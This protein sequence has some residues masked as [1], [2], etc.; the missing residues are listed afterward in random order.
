MRPISFSYVNTRKLSLQNKSDIQKMSYRTVS[1]NL[2]FG[3]LLLFVES[4]REDMDSHYLTSLELY[5]RFLTEQNV[6]DTNKRRIENVLLANLVKVSDLD[7]V[8]ETVSRCDQ[9]TDKHLFF[10]SLDSLECCDR[11]L[12]N[13][14]RL[15]KRFDLN[16][17][18][19]E[20]IG[21]G[22]RHTV[23]ELCSLL[24]TYNMP[25]KAKFNVALEN[26][27][28]A[29]FKAGYG[30]CP[31]ESTE[32]IVEYFLT[33]ESVI[34]DKEYD[35][36]INV[37]ETNRFINK[38]NPELEYVF[39]A[40]KVKGNSFKDKAAELV[41]QCETKECAAHMSQLAKIKNEKQASAYID[42][43]IEMIIADEI[44]K[45]DSL[46]LLK[47]IYIIPLMGNVSKE[48]VNYKVEMSRSKIKMKKKITGVKNDAFI[49]DLLDDG[50]MIDYASFVSE[51]TS[52]P[53][54]ILD[55]NYIEETDPVK[56]LEG[57]GSTD[58]IKDIIKSFKA[59]NE[60]ST[61]KFRNMIS[62]IMTKSPENIIDETP[63]IFSVVRIM[64]YLGV[65]ASSPLGPVFAAILTLVGKLLTMHLDIKQAEK[66]VRH[67]RSEKEK[68]EKKLEKLSG[69]EKENQEEYIDCI[70]KC[71]KKVEKFIA[72]IDDENEEIK[73]KGDDDF[74]FDF[75][76]DDLEESAVAYETNP[77][78]LLLNTTGAKEII[79]SLE[80][81]MDDEILSNI[82]VLF[83]NCPL[84]IKNE[85]YAKLDSLGIDT[86]V[87]ESGR[88]TEFED[89]FIVQFEAVQILNELSKD[90]KKDN[91]KVKVLPK[92]NKV[93][94]LKN[95]EIQKD[96]KNNKEIPNKV[97]N[98][99]QDIKGKIN[100]GI[101]NGKNNIKGNNKGKQQ[102][103]GKIN[104]T[105]LKMAV[106]NFKKKF[107]DLKGKE[108]ELWRNIDIATVNLSKGVQQA[109]TSDRREAIIKGSI[110][111]SFSKCIK[112]AIG[113]GAI[114]AF[115]GPVGA[116]IA[117]V[118]SLGASKALN[119][120]ERK[121]IYD[122]IDTELQVVEK[123]IQM[124]ESEGDM[125]QYRFLLNYE[126][127]LKR[128]RHRIK[129]G[130]H[131]SGRTLPELKGGHD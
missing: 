37:L 125:N 119:D 44:T 110:I 19:I 102:G 8:R 26:V 97:N 129:Y 78:S 105:T 10:E 130:V 118:G 5:N 114:G 112:F 74:D 57:S 58:E 128:E 3:N 9:I 100:N 47:S 70:E 84:D 121:L 33:R 22:M 96:N 73:G 31:F 12:R 76:L 55:D 75:D 87:R 115:V 50:E 92:D 39:E 106:I 77:L 108:A 120:R 80:K 62:R 90:L 65:A 27:N 126:K 49:K 45:N 17:T 60:K 1:D 93:K 69:K 29:L 40:K 103:S 46:L 72:D 111:P 18:I 85:F 116:A 25:A 109:L 14:A 101:N 34:T 7:S 91:N 32:F 104:L 20:S 51:S 117:L 48:F 28:Y 107:R 68:A 13:E 83:D 41:T 99:F 113:I 53:E 98:K 42:K 4:S 131:M 15:S 6:S 56:L 124:A 43:S 63:N 66:L 35:G 67:L 36:Y 38:D 64:I 30:Y 123:Q 122:E 23:F 88:I 52:F 2:N 59:S 11:I 54:Y 94:D 86:V 82:A 89:S 79:D 71:I 21:Y 95:K 127:K 81:P 24:D 16:K 61:G